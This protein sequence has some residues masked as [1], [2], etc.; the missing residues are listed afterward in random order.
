MAQ[1]HMA[2]MGGPVGGG[3][4]GLPIPANPITQSMTPELVMRKLNTAIYEYMICNEKYDIARSI[5]KS[6]PV[7]TTDGGMKQSP[8]TH[9]N[10]IDPTM[11][12]D[13][14]ETIN[15]K[16]RPDDLPAPASLFPSSED[17]PFLQDWWCMFWDLWKG[18][19]SAGKANTLTYIGAQR[20]AQKARQSMMGLDPNAVQNGMR[21]AQMNGNIPDHLRVQAMQRGM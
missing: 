21:V 5:L 18:Q 2:A 10:G 3:P 15:M 16:N 9:P 7:E 8:K 19:R 17:H 4:M 14:K 13:S 12:L 11:D 6:M 1:Q 20:Q